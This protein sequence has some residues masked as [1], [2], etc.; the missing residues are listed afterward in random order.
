MSRISAEDK[1]HKANALS[2]SGRK[3]A[4]LANLVK[5][6]EAP[7]YSSEGLRARSAETKNVRGARFSRV[8]SNMAK[9]H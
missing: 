8:A 3:I 6:N 4:N 1:S 7:S 2:K 5:K 9:T